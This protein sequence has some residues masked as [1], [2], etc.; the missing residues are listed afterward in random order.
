MK[1]KIEKLQ[2]LRNTLLRNDPKEQHIKIVYT[3]AKIEDIEDLKDTITT[4][5]SLI[6][7]ENKQMRIAI[8]DITDLM[9]EIQ[10]DIFEKN[11]KNTDKKEVIK[12]RTFFDKFKDNIFRNVIAIVMG[13]FLTVGSLM[14]LRKMDANNFDNTAKTIK[15]TRKVAK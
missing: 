14:F 6:N 11:H 7:T 15:E 12:K 5:L 4:I 8:S 10:L 3:I 9:L 13:I 1:E 2:K